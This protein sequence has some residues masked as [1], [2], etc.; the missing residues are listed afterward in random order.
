MSATTNEDVQQLQKLVLH[1]P[2]LIDCTA[3]GAE[4]N[5]MAGSNVAGTSS[6]IQHFSIQCDRSGLA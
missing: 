5:D 1:N 3:N 2:T 4:A 6:Q